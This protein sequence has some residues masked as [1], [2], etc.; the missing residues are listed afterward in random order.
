MPDT[1]AQ[2][3]LL[4][5]IDFEIG[6]LDTESAQHG[7]TPWVLSGALGAALWLLSSELV[8]HELDLNRV[9][10]FA[11]AGATVWDLLAAIFGQ[12][13]DADDTWT[14]PGRFRFSDAYL[15]LRPTILFWIARHAL[16]SWSAFHLAARVGNSYLILPGI[17]YATAAFFFGLAFVLAHLRIILGESA[18]RRTRGGSYLTGAAFVCLLVVL[19]WHAVAA[20]HPSTNLNLYELR[21]AGLLLVIAAVLEKLCKSRRVHFLRTLLGLRRDLV[22]GRISHEQGLRTYDSVVAGLTVSEQYS[23]DVE[24]VIERQLQVA[25]VLEI[26]AHDARKLIPAEPV[27]DEVLGELIDRRNS[28]CEQFHDAATQMTSLW[29]R[30]TSVARWA[31]A[32]ELEPLFASVDEGHRL[33]DEKLDQAD[34][35]IEAYAPGRIRNR[36][37]EQADL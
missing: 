19:A 10:S 5:Q 22:L 1:P 26:L 6:R 32:S 9:L 2:E 3:H 7:A 4:S 33:L 17:A 11:L 16:L 24:N 25:S 20:A 14:A 30:L 27:S 8:A 37:G 31:P 15:D 18:S 34:A 23:A 36:D 35:A 29:K 13:V 28:A 12:D 21:T